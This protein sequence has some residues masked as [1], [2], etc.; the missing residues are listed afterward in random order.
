MF[1]PFISLLLTPAR[2]WSGSREAAACPVHTHTLRPQS[3]GDGE[4]LQ[5]VGGC[6]HYTDQLLVVVNQHFESPQ[7]LA[8]MLYP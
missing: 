3:P 8:N 2:S 4:A 7:L 6:K 1:Y 5:S